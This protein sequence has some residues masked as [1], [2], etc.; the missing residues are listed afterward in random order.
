MPS[1]EELLNEAE[2]HMAAQPVNDVLEI[3]PETR[4]ISIPDSEIIL[5][6]ETDQ[7]AERKYFHCPKIVGNNIDLSELELYVVFQNASNMEEGKD[8]YHVTDVKTTSDGYITFSWELSAKVTAYK[9]DVQFVVC[10]IK[11]DSSGVKQNVWNTTIAIGKCLIGLSSDMS[12][13]EEQSA[14][15]LYTQLISELNS[16]ASAKLAEVTTQIQA[17]G[18][19]QVSNVNNAGTTQVNNVQNK[20][21]EVLASIPDTYAELDASVKVL[22][23]QI[24]GK[25]PV[26]TESITIQSGSPT[27]V[28]DSAEMP[29]QGLRVYGKSKQVTTTGKQ[30]YDVNNRYTDN[31]LFSTKATV[32]KYGYITMMLPL[33]TTGSTVFYN[34]FTKESSDV[35]Y[36]VEYNIVV[37]ILSLPSNTNISISSTDSASQSMQDH[38]LASKGKFSRKITFKKSTSES[39]HT[40]L[41]TFVYQLS[42]AQAGV[43]KFRLS[44]IKDLDSIDS[45]VYEPY[46]G[47]KPSPS[48]EYPQEIVSVGEKGSIEVNVRGKNLADIYGYSANGMDNPEEKRVL[49]NEYGTTLNTTE[50]TD[51]LIVNQEILDGAIA[52]NYT[53]GYFCIGINRKFEV[54]EYYIITFRINVIRNPL[55]M[56]EVFVSFNGITFSKAEVIGDKVTVKAEYKELGKRQYVEVRNNGMSVELSDFM[57]TEVGETDDYEPYKQSTATIPLQNGLQG[58]PVTTG[59]NYTDENGQQYICD[60]IDFS[61]GKY[62][63]RVWQAEFDGSEDEKWKK[64]DANYI[65]NECLPVVM[66]SRK[67][68]CNQYIVGNNIRGIKIGDGTKALIVF[69]DFSDENA[70]SNFKAHLASNP[71]S[72]MTYLDTPIETDLTEAQIQAYKSLTTFKPT[73]IISNDAGAQM[74]VEYACD[75]KTWV[76]NK[77]N[78]LIKEATT[79]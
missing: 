27:T 1:I 51:K 39:N 33:N 67:G 52:G 11:T 22:N 15:D 28:T 48:P 73:S 25:A 64:G 59:G 21:T 58:I 17:V 20:G 71:L 46:T 62:V 16:T 45:F 8:R 79:L 30:L 5:G 7:K 56:S 74:N 13:S 24:R 76:T 75:T 57:I 61:R 66:N 44:V 12:E 2:S 4:E 3:N 42:G 18:N 47:G 60:E 14:S 37:E 77:I 6:V 41:R 19:N 35:E 43:V 32:D 70:L 78:T 68:F 26:I 69:D 72:V 31:A 34:L 38:V 65:S 54:D 40:M 55:S 23:E 53:S 36:G 9:G 63:Q 10:A 49:N 50:K 29:L